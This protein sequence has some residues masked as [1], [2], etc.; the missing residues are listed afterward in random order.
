MAD[1]TPTQ[2]IAGLTP[3]LCSYQGADGMYSIVL[4][5]SDPEQI[6]RDHG[7]D[8]HRLQVDGVLHGT[9]DVK[10]NPHG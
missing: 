2:N 6:V 1:L 10:E 7:A 9:M 4:Y 3:F 8:L 5:G